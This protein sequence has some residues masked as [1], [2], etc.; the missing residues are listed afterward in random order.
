MSAS[1]PEEPGCRELV[2]LSSREYRAARASQ[3]HFL[4][5]GGH[6]FRSGAVV[7]QHDGYMVV[8]KSG[9]AAAVIEREEGSDG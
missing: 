6:P 2:R 7:E 9:E 5:V 8:E 1:A 4:L 3:R